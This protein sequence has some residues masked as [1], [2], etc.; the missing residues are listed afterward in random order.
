MP[1]PG[2]EEG[3]RRVKNWQKY[4]AEVYGTFVLVLF[5]T[6]AILATGGDPVGIALG[7]GLALVAGLFT[8]GRISGGHFNPAVSFGFALTKRLS[9]GGMIRYWIAQLAGAA[10][11]GWLLGVIYQGA[12]VEA[13]LGA[14]TV[15]PEI[16]APIAALIEGVLTFFLVIV[17]FA[18]AV[19]PRAP[20]GFA[21]FA[22]GMAITMDILMAGSLTGG[23]VNPARAFGPAFA[24]GYWQDHWVYWAGPLLG[25]AVAAFVYD[26]FFLERS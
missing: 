23:A 15:T 25:G 2:F 3:R 11:A 19:D 4:A 13:H 12:S 1:R 6:G 5:G 8:V 21:G 9:W 14:T 20:K 18:T 7:F 16:G 26:R 17:I 24:A 22:I 10:I